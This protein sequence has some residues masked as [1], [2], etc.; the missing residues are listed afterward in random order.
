MRRPLRFGETARADSPRS[1]AQLSVAP[2][3]AVVALEEAL[4]PMLEALCNAALAHAEK[5]GR[6][7]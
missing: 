3:A 4:E 5:N 7:T 6:E 2:Q 1:V